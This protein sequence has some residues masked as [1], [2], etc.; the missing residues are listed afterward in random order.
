[1][2]QAQRGGQW[3]ALGVF[4]FAGG[5]DYAITL[6]DDANGTVVADAVYIV[7]VEDLS[8]AVTWAPALPASGSYQVY[9]RWT[10]DE[11]RAT[12]RAARRRSPGT[13]A[14]AAASGTTSAP[15]PSIR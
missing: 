15:T 4:A 2:S 13:S 7:K 10:A 12:D 5:Q 9:A 8:D 3:N 14:W 1:V 11:T 6:S